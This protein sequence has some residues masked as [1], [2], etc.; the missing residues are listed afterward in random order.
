MENFEVKMTKLTPIPKN[1]M[2]RRQ[3][4][5][6]CVACAVMTSCAS[7]KSDDLFASGSMPPVDS[8]ND[9]TTPPADSASATDTSTPTDTSSDT[10]ETGDTSPSAPA[11]SYEIDLTQQTDLTQVG[12]VEFFNAD[13]I[14]FAVTR[15]GPGA[16]EFSVVS[17]F[18]THQGCVVMEDA[19]AAT[20]PGLG[21]RWYVCPCHDARFDAMGTVLNG[22]AQDPLPEFDFQ[23]SGN[24]LYVI[25]V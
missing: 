18:C 20:Q 15:I 25:V 10:G 7:E 13:G 19:D 1:S 24:S 12:G 22:P 4:L 9:D 3:F 5:K 21:E 14:V 6:S 17:G 23:V 11:N 8:P 16:D 2:F